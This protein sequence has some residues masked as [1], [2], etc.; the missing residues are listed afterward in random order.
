[1]M[2]VED[3]E[4]PVFEEAEMEEATVETNETMTILYSGVVSFV[5]VS[6]VGVIDDETTGTPKAKSAR[7]PVDIGNEWSDWSTTVPEGDDLIKESRTE[8]RYK[9][10]KVIKQTTAPATPSAS[11]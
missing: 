2:M 9:D 4:A 6:M 8:Y 7:A 11:S 5:E 10:R 1:M 3:R